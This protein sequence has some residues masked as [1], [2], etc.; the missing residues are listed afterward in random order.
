MVLAGGGLV[1]N[2]TAQ[3]LAAAAVAA[4]AVNIGGG[5]TITQR[6]LDMFKRPTDPPEYNHLFAI[7]GAAMLATYAA[8]HFTGAF[9]RHGGG[10]AGGGLDT[11]GCCRPDGATPDPSARLHRSAQTR[12]QPLGQS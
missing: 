9:V 10:R 11:W 1:P 2:T 4:S 3:G 5:F 6:M 12:R 7:P 8:G